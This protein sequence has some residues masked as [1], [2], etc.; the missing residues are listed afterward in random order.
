MAM[1]MNSIKDF[2]DKQMMPQSCQIQQTVS[3]LRQ[4]QGMFFWERGG[5]TFIQRL[6]RDELYS[7]EEIRNWL[8]D[9]YDSHSLSYEYSSE[10]L[11]AKDALACLGE[12]KIK[13]LI[14]EL[15]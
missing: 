5:K 14:K 13:Q 3:Y 9:D 10:R 2:W 4:R 15:K 7:L 6:L 1:K 11:D 8:N 12:D